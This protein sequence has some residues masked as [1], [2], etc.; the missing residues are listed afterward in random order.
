MGAPHINIL[1]PD[2]KFCA[3]AFPP[4]LVNLKSQSSVFPF[5]FPHTPQPLRREREFRI[6]G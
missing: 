1:Q 6:L 4:D 3:S 5:D 2:R